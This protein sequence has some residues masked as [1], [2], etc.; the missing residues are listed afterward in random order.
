MHSTA[1]TRR[2]HEA[3]KGPTVE[4]LRPSSLRRFVTPSLTPAAFTLVEI[5]IV[6]GI[7][8]L[9]LA[10]A[11]PAFNYMTG[12][13]SIE[14][15]E[16]T[17][18]AMLGRAR[19]EALRKQEP[20]GIAFFINPTTNR[21]TMGMVYYDPSGTGAIDLLPDRDF[22]PLQ[23]GVAAAFM[24]DPAHHPSGHRYMANGVILFDSNG[25]LTPRE[26]SLVT[27]TRLVDELG[28]LEVTRRAQ[29]GIMLYDRQVFQNVGGANETDQFNWIDQNGHLLLVNRYNGTLIRGE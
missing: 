3:T 23:P 15:A 17:I 10:M 19:A 6:I 21:L 25:K 22:Q 5:L 13:R 7:I 18:S 14:A 16:N 4:G 1:T 20:R 28:W 24:S 26:Y 11:V 2:R 12:A 27:G 8:V 29:F 9:V